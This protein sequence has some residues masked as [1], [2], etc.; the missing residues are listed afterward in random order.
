MKLVLD[1]ERWLALIERPCAATHNRSTLPIL[2]FLALRVA[3]RHL[4]AIGTDLITTATSHLELESDHEDE[5]ICV[6][7]K[8]L[9]DVI[10]SM[11]KESSI[12]LETKESAA[13]LKSGRSRFKLEIADIQ[14]YPNPVDDDPKAMIKIDASKFSEQIEFV[15]HAMANKDVRYYLN[16]LHLSHDSKGSLSV[17]AT[18]GHRAAV[19]TRPFAFDSAQEF[20]LIVDRNSVPHLIKFIADQD[21]EIELGAHDRRIEVTGKTGSVS[22]QLIIG[23]YP[24]VQRIVPTTSKIVAAVD[25]A[26]LI[27][28]AGRV[29]MASDNRD[30]G[31]LLSVFGDKI[32]LVAFK[33]SNEVGEDEIEAVV[34]NVERDAGSPSLD[35]G[36]NPTYLIDALSSFSESEVLLRFSDSLGPIRIDAG[37][38]SSPFED[39]AC[40]IVMPCRL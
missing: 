25:R 20:S 4:I 8:K 19:I 3:N 10:R 26:K 13:T 27:E 11:P 22:C 16:G 40:C 1:R 2:G 32:R 21:S 23:K 14:D 12:T 28:I 36:L 39:C 5:A 30:N 15:K 17:Q 29:A 38:G 33:G 34:P 9:L 24:D 6:E 37:G 31:I 35:V 18:D 7:S